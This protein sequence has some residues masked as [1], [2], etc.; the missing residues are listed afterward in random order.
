MQGD[1]VPT[2][3]GAS[4][5]CHPVMHARNQEAA[6]CAPCSESLGWRPLG[7]EDWYAALT[8]PVDWEDLILTCLHGAWWEAEEAC[9]E[10]NTR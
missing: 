4:F 7:S 5:P 1:V 10:G 6:S 9:R 8:S 2:R 3:I